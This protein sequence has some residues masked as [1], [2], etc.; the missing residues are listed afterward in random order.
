MKQPKKN[1]RLHF[2]LQHPQRLV[3]AMQSVWK[4]ST[5]SY[6]SN[7]DRNVN[8]GFWQPTT[9]QPPVVGL[10]ALSHTPKPAASQLNH[11]RVVGARTQQSIGVQYVLWF[12]QSGLLTQGTHRI[13]LYRN[14]INSLTV[15]VC[16]SHC[17][18]SDSFP[19]RDVIVNQSSSYIDGARF[20]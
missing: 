9:S 4:A 20:S 12:D 17:H 6:C 2:T 11:S 14:S 18:V 3:I 19:R 10:L 1:I 13:R 8:S 5:S 16:C 7:N 15:M